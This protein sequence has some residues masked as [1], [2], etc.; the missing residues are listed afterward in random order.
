MDYLPAEATNCKWIQNV[1]V[2]QC[3]SVDYVMQNNLTVCLDCN[4]SLVF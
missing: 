3:Q 2:S 4:L 1:N